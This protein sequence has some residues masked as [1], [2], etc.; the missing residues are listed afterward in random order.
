MDRNFL[1]LMTHSCYLP[2]KDHK[3]FFK[4]KEHYLI[5]YNQFLFIF[6]LMIMKFLTLSVLTRRNCLIKMKKPISK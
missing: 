1:N 4:V 5:W 3:T 6:N 2:I